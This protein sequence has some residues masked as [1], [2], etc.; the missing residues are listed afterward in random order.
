M[1]PVE[2]LSYE[3]ALQEL[4]D[5]VEAL[6]RGDQ[7]LEEAMR[8]FERGRQL[9]QHCTQLLTQARLKLRLLTEVEEIPEDLQAFLD[10]EG[11][12]A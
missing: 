6:E 3:E 9:L 7:S 2:Q 1:R 11:D 5:V 4:Q 10:Q 12:D 8:L